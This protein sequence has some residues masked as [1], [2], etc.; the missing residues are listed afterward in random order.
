MQTDLIIPETDEEISPSSKQSIS[1]QGLP[2]KKNQKAK[3]LNHQNRRKMVPQNT[4]A[5]AGSSQ[6]AKDLSPTIVDDS[7]VFHLKARYSRKAKAASETK[8]L[9]NSST[10]C[11]DFEIITPASSK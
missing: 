6:L 8:E 11:I 2:P 4:V 7:P 9:L 10:S 5:V 3:K 1:D